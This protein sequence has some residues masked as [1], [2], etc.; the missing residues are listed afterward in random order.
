M[1]KSDKKMLEEGVI[2]FFDKKEE[3][4]SLSNFSALEVVI[5][6]RNYESGEHAYHG[7]KY[8]LL[9]ELCEDEK[10]KKELIDYS[11]KFVKPSLFGYGNEVKSKGGKKG[12]IINESERSIWFDIGINLQRKICK[13]K[14]D[15][16]VVVR[17]D[18]IKSGTK[19]LVHPAMRCNEEKVKEKLWE[20]RGIIVDG[21]IEIIGMNML[22]KLWMELR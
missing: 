5:G 10:R 6:E 12:L 3:Y 19:L 20:G 13:Y 4:K 1:N 18:L 8:R 9:G 7:E 2:N 11:E 22:G 16:Y 14:Y 15:N 21:K 17:T